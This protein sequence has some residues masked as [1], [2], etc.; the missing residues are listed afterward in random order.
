MAGEA[1][2]GAMGSVEAVRR[3]PEGTDGVFWFA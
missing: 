2:I 3:A 1:I